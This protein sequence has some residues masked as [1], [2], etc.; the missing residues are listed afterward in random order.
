MK[1][2]H[3]SSLPFRPGQRGAI[4]PLAVAAMLAI[5][6]LTGAGIDIGFIVWNKRQ[7]HSAV[8]AAALA[9]AQDLLGTYADQ[10][11]ATQRITQTVNNYAARYAQGSGGGGGGQQV[12]GSSRWYN[13]LARSAN[14]TVNPPSVELQNLGKSQVG[15]NPGAQSGANALRVTQTA[16]IRP[17]FMSLFGMD[18]I[19]ISARASA[20]AGG[21]SGAPP[22]NVSVVVDTTGSMNNTNVS[23]GTY[24]TV[25]RIRCAKYGMLSLV[26]QLTSTGN[27][28]GLT[29]F[30]PRD[31]SAVLSEDT[32]CTYNNVGSGDL[33]DYMA[34]NSPYFW[35]DTSTS[36]STIVAWANAA[37]YYQNGAI[38]TSNTLIQAIGRSAANIANNCGVDAPGGKGTFYAQAIRQAQYN[39]ESL[40]NDQQNIM[41]L[42]SDG[43]ASSTN[44]APQVQ[45]EGM[46]YDGENAS[47]TGRISGFAR[48]TGRIGGNRTTAYSTPADNGN[49][50]RISNI[51]FGPLESGTGSPITGGTF[52]GT[53]SRL[54][55]QNGCH[56]TTATTTGTTTCTGTLTSTTGTYQV[57]A[58]ATISTDTVFTQVKTGRTLTVTAVGSGTLVLGEGIS[59][60]GIAS[61]TKVIGDS[62]TGSICPTATSNTALCTGNGGVGTYLVDTN[63]RMSSNITI[64]TS[65]RAGTT[66]RVSR[67]IK[68]SL[69]TGLN[70]E[71]ASPSVNTTVTAMATT[72][73]CVNATNRCT[74]TGTNG[75]T[76]VPATY[77][78]ANSY[79][80]QTTTTLSVFGDEQNNQCQ[81]AIVA[82]NDAKAAGTQIYVLSYG[83]TTSSGC[84]TD[85]TSNSTYT[86][87][88]PLSLSGIATR[89]CNTLQ[90]IAGDKN[91]QTNTRPGSANKFFFSTS[92]TCTSPNAYGDINTLFQEIAEGI[93]NV[94]SRTIPDDAW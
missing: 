73:G 74:G 63:H 11:A 37:N 52:S 41:I 47:V 89:P 54:S 31:S 24:G 19:T 22:V 70:L 67:V 26:S 81:Q 57:S 4:L 58:N 53:I 90:W 86:T 55:P 20:S 33:A 83:A 2:F 72:T 3:H 88:S 59:G 7:L 40:N 23:C 49:T 18:S 9:G 78:L 29:V 12:S 79:N 51:A 39:F 43:D 75:T 6:G 14:V 21:G 62:T 30:P 85:T 10:A 80:I 50:L 32:D 45:V 36:I 25:S 44:F 1:A 77:K 8:E 16:I 94:G 48:F 35:R 64:T 61:N 27:T 28:V 17:F 13:D 42:L 92:N 46:I 76:S 5:V 65:R 82:A 93:T 34:G 69:T 56:D 68:G 71:S 84:S 15:L 66:L 91:T 87:L 38:N 60:S